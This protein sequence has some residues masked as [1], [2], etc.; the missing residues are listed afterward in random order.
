MGDYYIELLTDFGFGDQCQRIAELYANHATRASAKDAVTDEMMDALAI[1]GSPE[2][3]VAELQRRRAFGID[4]H[5]LSLPSNAPWE[6]VENF[7]RA[8]APR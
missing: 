2:E 3:C 4:L 5:I 8:M 7:V 6:V 1:T